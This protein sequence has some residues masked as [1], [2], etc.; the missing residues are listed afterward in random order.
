MVHERRSEARRVGGVALV[1]Q[2]LQVLPG[3]LLFALEGADGSHG[4]V[5]ILAS[6]KAPLLDDICLQLG[7]GRPE[8]LGQLLILQAH[9]LAQVVE[10][11]WVPESR[12]DRE[13]LR[14]A[15]VPQIRYVLPSELLVL[16][17]H[18][19]ASNARLRIFDSI[20]AQEAAVA[21]ALHGFEAQGQVSSLLGSDVRGG[22]EAIGGPHPSLGQTLGLVEKSL[23]LFERLCVFLCRLWIDLFRVTLHH[24]NGVGT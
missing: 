18:G 11:P 20:L 4:Y 6:V 16:N 2:L 13:V 17:V 8:R 5:L 3:V 7:Y 9:V 24:I 10:G 23:S 22:I 15:F 14:V 21:E 12:V 19:F 1:S